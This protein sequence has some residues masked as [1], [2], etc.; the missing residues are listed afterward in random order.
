MAAIMF[1][2]SCSKDDDTSVEKQNIDNQNT[3]ESP[4]DVVSIPFSIKVNTGKS[5]T[6][7]LSYDQSFINF[8]GVDQKMI[9]SCLSNGY[10]DVSGELGLAKDGEW[11]Y[12]SGDILC[13]KAHVDALTNGDITLTGTYGTAL[14]KPAS[15]NVSLDELRQNCA[16]QYKTEFTFKSE[17]IFLTDQNAYLE[18][19][20]SPLQRVLEVNGE[21]CTLDKTSGNVWV[22]V[23]SNKALSVG[24]F[25]SKDAEDVLPGK[26]F[27]I[28]RANCVDLGS[29]Y[30][31]RKSVLWVDH[32]IGA[33]TP[34]GY[35][36]YYAWGET[37]P[38]YSS[39][40]PLIWK[41]NGG[42]YNWYTYKYAIDDQVSITKYCEV[43]DFGYNGFEDNLTELGKYK[44]NENEEP[45]DDDVAHV[46]NDQWSMP[47]YEELYFLQS[48][49]YWV[50]VDNYNESG[51]SGYIVYKNQGSEGGSVVYSGGTVVSGYSI[52]D[53]PHIFLPIA[54]YFDDEDFTSTSGCYWSSSNYRSSPSNSYCLILSANNV[55]YN[56]RH[57]YYGYSVRAVR[58]SNNN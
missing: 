36:D 27:T 12:F 25:L 55:N 42:Y 58:R 31:W 1:A 49:C 17:N 19:T 41:K 29:Q 15:S 48:E 40:N 33:S 21:K 24:S 57:R 20:M 28:N 39:L 16:H 46:T 37:E 3:I 2:T 10:S 14:S 11:Y 43:S 56:N 30:S 4:D 38:Y 51:K 44:I 47:D 50:W 7:S 18:I 52:N 26:I 35:G 22:A 13:N 53:T 23:P 5:L 6:K 54:G 8:V 9:I 34:D 45:I 32:N